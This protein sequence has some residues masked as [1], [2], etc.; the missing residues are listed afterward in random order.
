MWGLLRLRPV[1]APITCQPLRADTLGFLPLFQGRRW[2]SACSPPASSWR[3]MIL[4][5]ISAGDGLRLFRMVPE[6]V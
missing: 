4:P 1:H 6:V 5:F 2:A 3:W